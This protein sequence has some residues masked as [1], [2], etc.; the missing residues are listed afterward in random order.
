MS[1]L[2][3]LKG[4]LEA[5]QQQVESL[6]VS[7]TDDKNE[8]M[9]YPSYKS[10]FFMHTSQNLQEDMDKQESSFRKFGSITHQLLKESH[11]S[12]AET[13]NRALQEVNAR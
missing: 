13:L 11:P 3:L 2:H 6:E 1:R 10:F 9:K 8:K 7:T 4:S 5:V 12:V